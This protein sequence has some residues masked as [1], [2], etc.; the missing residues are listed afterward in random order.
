MKTLADNDAVP[1]LNA[2]HQWTISPN[3][4]LNQLRACK[5]CRCYGAVAQLLSVAVVVEDVSLRG[6]SDG[7]KLPAALTP[8]SRTL[9]VLDVTDIGDINDVRS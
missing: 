1:M 3:S 8:A 6:A 5:T 4:V 2:A 9:R 7:G